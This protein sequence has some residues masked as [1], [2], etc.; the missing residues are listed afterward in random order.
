MNRAGFA[1]DTV[2]LSV[3]ESNAI[4]RL[5][6]AISLT[7]SAFRNLRPFNTHLIA[8]LANQLPAEPDFCPA[9]HNARHMI[10]AERLMIDVCRCVIPSLVRRIKTTINRFV[11]LP[12]AD[13]VSGNVFSAVEIG[14]RHVV[15]SG[16]GSASFR[17]R[18]TDPRLL[19]GSASCT[20]RF[21]CSWHLWISARFPKTDLTAR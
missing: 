4:R 17:T 6:C 5:L 15:V 10:Y 9:K 7:R 18:L 1:I 14:Q 11:R 16:G 3:Y 19:S 8:V 12:Y 21:L 13:V 2:R 20:F